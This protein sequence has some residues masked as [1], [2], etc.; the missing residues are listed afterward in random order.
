MFEVL[1]VDDTRSVHAFVRSLLAKAADIQVTSAYNGKEAVELLKGGKKFDLIFLD[2]EMP[3][4]NGPDTFQEMKGLG[5]T[6]PIVMMT[7]KNSPADIQRMLEQ[8]VAEYLM[9]PFTIDIL[10]E[11]L[12]FASGRNFDYGK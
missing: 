1:V 11:K 6:I 2:W 5:C 7:T 8:G 10:F 3:E 9:K 12:S 4:L